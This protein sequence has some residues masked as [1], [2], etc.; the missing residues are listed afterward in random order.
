MQSAL[1]ILGAFTIKVRFMGTW[2]PCSGE[3]VHRVRLN[4]HPLLR[5]SRSTRYVMWA[6][7]PAIFAKCI[8]CFVCFERD[9]G[10]WRNLRTVKMLRGGICRS[11]ISSDD[12]DDEEVESDYALQQKTAMKK[13]KTATSAPS[14]TGTPAVGQRAQ[15]RPKT[16]PKE[17]ATIP[18]KKKQPSSNSKKAKVPRVQVRCTL[19]ASVCV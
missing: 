11:P 18:Q 15:R 3:R 9:S 10:Y 1:L 14:A 8:F 16:A 13:Q 2:M 7:S 17:T 6:T 4:S 12:D 19:S 5:R